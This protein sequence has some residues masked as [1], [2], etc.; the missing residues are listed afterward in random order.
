M[1]RLNTRRARGVAA[2]VVTAL[3]L[4]ACVQNDM[5][6]QTTRVEY[7]PACYEPVA[8][9]RKANDHFSEVIA[10]GVV[11]GAMTG[12][13]AGA[14]TTKGRDKGKGAAIGA[15]GGA[16]A[17]GMAAYA[18]A[19]RKEYADTRQRMAS[20]AADMRAA[21][22]GL[23]GTNAAGRAATACYDREFKALVT[24]VK[25]GTMSKE[26]GRKR[27]AEIKSGLDEVATLMGTVAANAQKR[28]D[29][30]QTA[31]SE[32]AKSNSELKGYTLASATT[33]TKSSNK[34]N[35][36]ASASTKDVVNDGNKYATDAKDS[37]DISAGAS[38]QA[39]STAKMAGTIGLG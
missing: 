39:A 35:K 22:S 33:T 32:E 2:V 30:F 28:K 29:E 16:M 38:E 11:M 10:A 13:L 21:S 19:N 20:Y 37:K 34:T 36:P 4:T 15:I 12:A 31:V 27:Y 1:M 6:P 7:Y 3:S 9:L 17:G 25:A 24:S 8:Q 26:D 18:Q 23:Q 14:L 5:A